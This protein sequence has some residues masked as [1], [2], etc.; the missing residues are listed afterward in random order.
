[1]SPIRSLDQIRE[2]LVD[3]PVSNNSAMSAAK[4]REANLLKQ[5][6]FLGRIEELAEWLCGWQGHH[7]PT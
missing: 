3:L 6:G 4:I 1:M 5:P 7:P 2:L